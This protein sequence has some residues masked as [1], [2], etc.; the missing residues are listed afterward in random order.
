MIIKLKEMRNKR[1]LTQR[2]LAKIC[3]IDQLTLS[4]YET[5]KTHP[6][7]DA[8]CQIAQAL[9]CTLDDLVQV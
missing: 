6:R 2:Q 8:L 3:G 1:E 7:L 4:T 9:N 5:G